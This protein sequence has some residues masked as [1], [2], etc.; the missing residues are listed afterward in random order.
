MGIVRF[1]SLLIGASLLAACGG[2]SNTG[3]D[4]GTSPGPGTGTGDSGCSGSCATASSFLTEDDIRRIIA[5][6]VNEAQAQNAPATITVV[7]RVGNVLGA[8][9]MTNARR[10]QRVDSGRGITGGLEGLQIPSELTAIAKAI[11]SV[12]FSSEGNAFTSRTAGQAA[13]NGRI[14]PRRSMRR[15]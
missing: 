3:S 9:R 11:T 10:T 8:Y 14:V 6:A 1:S 12:Y 2:G 5:Q 4:A 15:R 13:S 7:D